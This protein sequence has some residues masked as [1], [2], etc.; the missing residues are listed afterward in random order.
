MPLATNISGAPISLTFSG[1]ASG[2]ILMQQYGNTGG[3]LDA[4]Q[5]GYIIEAGYSADTGAQL[6][7]PVN[8]TEPANTRVSF[9][10]TSNGNTGQAIGDGVFVECNLNTEESHWLQSLYRRKALGIS[11]TSKR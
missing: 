10:S 11:N 6:W 1:I 9:G 7:G 4:F 3:M 5:S 8:R 2:V